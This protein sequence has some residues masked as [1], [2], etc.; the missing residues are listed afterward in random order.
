MAKLKIKIVLTNSVVKFLGTPPPPPPRILRE[1]GSFILR[2]D[3][4]K[5]IRE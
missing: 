3:G 2:E 5:I 1:D 4:S